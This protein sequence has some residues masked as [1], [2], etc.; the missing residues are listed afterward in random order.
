M[1]KID[2]ARRRCNMSRID[3][4]KWRRKIWIIIKAHNKIVDIRVSTIKKILKLV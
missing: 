1:N 2:V 3:A 4:T